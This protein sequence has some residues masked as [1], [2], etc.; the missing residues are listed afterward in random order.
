[1]STRRTTLFLAALLGSCTFEDS[2]TSASAATTPQQTHMSTTP[3]TAPR[4]EPTASLP[5]IDRK[6]P[7]SIETATFALG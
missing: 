7:T 1:M 6:Q 2:G 5:E 4:T 3:G